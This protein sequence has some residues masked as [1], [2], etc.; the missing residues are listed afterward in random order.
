VGPEKK[1]Y[2]LH[3]ALLVHHSGY[4]RGA[5]SGDWV[6]AKEGTIHLEDVHTG[7]FNI[8]VNWIYAGQLPTSPRSGEFAPHDPEEFPG[9]SFAIG[10]L[11]AYIL[12]D[13]LIVPSLKDALFDIEYKW[14]SVLQPP[15]VKVAIFAFENL[16]ATDPFLQLLVDSYC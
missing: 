8:F 7:A 15:R 11:R 12:A 16:P 10:R 1:A 3:K 4:F 14:Y 2:T 5:L 6:E 13:M 9:C